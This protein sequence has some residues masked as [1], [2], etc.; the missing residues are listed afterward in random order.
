MNWV[1]KLVGVICLAAV[2]IGLYHLLRPLLP[3]W[4]GLACALLVILSGHMI[5]FTLSGMETMLFLALGI[6]ALL[7]YRDERWEW[8]GVALGLLIITRIE[9]IILA[10]VIGG[11]DMWRRKAIRRGLLVAGAVSILICGPWI[12][13]LW[14]R[15][16]YF[17]P[18]SGIGR[19]FSNIVAIQIATGR[20]ESLAWLRKF[21]ALAYPLV[22]IGYSVEFI[23]G[24]FALPAPYL[25]IDLGMGSIGYKLSVWSILG[26]A[27]VVLPLLCIGFRQLLFYIKNRGGEIGNAR[28]AICH[29]SDLDVLA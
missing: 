24:G 18:T 3:P 9:G 22:W 1:S 5:W 19:H 15:T 14:R 8:L 11:F 16:G 23:L 7:F 12:L 17:L 26:L 2:G 6:L 13:Y 21:P 20:V 27:T 10:L 29:L 4:V 28:P 25:E